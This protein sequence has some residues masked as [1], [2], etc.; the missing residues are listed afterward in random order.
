FDGYS[1][2][3]HSYKF[4]SL[5][6]VSAFIKKNKHLPG[7]TKID[8]LKKNVNGYSF[9]L[10]ALSIQSLEKIEELYLHVIEQQK[11]ID[12][13]NEEIEALRKALKDQTDKTNDRLQKLEK[14]LI[15]NK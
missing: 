8:D 10:T 7:V 12:A 5:A 6:D 11:Q 13:K 4:K 14:A 9:D 15:R 2:I 1:D 3:N